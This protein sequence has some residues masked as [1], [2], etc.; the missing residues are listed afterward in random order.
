MELEGTRWILTSLVDETGKVVAA[1]PQVEATATFEDGQVSGRSS[2]NR[3]GAGYT[4]EGNK[5]SISENMMSTMMACPEPLMNQEQQFQTALQAAATYAIEGST[6]HIANKAGVVVLIM[7][8]EIPLPLIGTSWVVRSYNNGKQA[9][10][11]ILAETEMTAQFDQD[12]SLAGSSGCNRY[13]ATYTL[14][15][16][17][18]AIGPVMGTRMMC[19]VPEGIMEQESL[20][21]MALS[22]SATW[23][24]EGKMLE[25][26]TD[27]GALVASFV[28]G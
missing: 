3:Y 17:G 9:V 5:L 27:E 1:L 19:M 28:A 12:G 6:L 13:R 26:R 10:V 24:I 23:R 22:T 14:D 8:A 7:E 18:T 20:Y 16:N 2:C 21:Q 25:L 11:S 15:G 4:L